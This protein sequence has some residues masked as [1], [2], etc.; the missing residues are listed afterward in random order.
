MKT[1]YPVQWLAGLASIPMSVFASKNKVRVV[2]TS[3]HGDGYR[4]N[5]RVLFEALCKHEEL[6]AIWLSRNPKLVK[7]LQQKYG[8][9]RACL[10][11]SLKGLNALATAAALLFTHGTS[12]FP[13]MRLPRRALFIQTYH[14]LPTKRG[15]YMRPKSDSEPNFLHKI[16]LRYRFEPI[17]YFLSSSPFVTDLFSRRFNLPEDRFV[18]TG[19]PCYDRLATAAPEPDFIRNNWPEAPEHKSVVLYSPTYR[20]MKKTRWFP[21]DDFD[22]E[23]LSRFLDEHNILMLFRPHPNDGFDRSSL[24]KI[25]SRC[26]YAGQEKIEDV[27]E[28]LIH[29]NAIITDYSSIYIEGLLRDIPSVFIPYDLDS[30]ERGQAYPYMEYTPGDKVHSQKQFVASLKKA[31]T[32]PSYCAEDK[33]RVRNSFF[34]RKDGEATERVIRFLEEK[35]LQ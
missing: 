33:V 21:F 29:T 11:H 12:D 5:T 2:L 20:K 9:E 17:D 6:E 22:P 30:Y 15:E 35:L 28:L 16:V 34:S 23:T 4:G 10:T 14:G 7:L 25:N 18:D 32:D 8:K 24:S 1:L 31:L 26:L 19:Y 13:F 3:F 27:Y